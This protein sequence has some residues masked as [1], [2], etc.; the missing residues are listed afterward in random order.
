MIAPTHSADVRYATDLARDNGCKTK[1]FG[2]D[3]IQTELFLV[4]HKMKSSCGVKRYRRANSRTREKDV[5]DTKLN[6]EQRKRQT[7]RTTNP[8]SKKQVVEISKKSKTLP[9]TNVNGVSVV[10]WV[11]CG[12]DFK[13]D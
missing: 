7:R 5:A 3:I 12:F 8:N 11:P 10:L 1:V 4:N 9:A 13:H 6:E 2:F